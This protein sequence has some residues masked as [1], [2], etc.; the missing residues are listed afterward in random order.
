MRIAIFWIGIGI[1]SLA[2]QDS[3]AKAGADTADKKTDFATA[4]QPE[5]DRHLVRE[6]E[7][8]LEKLRKTYS[9]QLAKCQ[10]GFRRS[11]DAALVTEGEIHD[12]A[13]ASPAKPN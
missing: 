9:K 10:D 12:L 1:A 7:K 2:A 5:S 3:M 11:C 4:N 13:A 8:R 6:R